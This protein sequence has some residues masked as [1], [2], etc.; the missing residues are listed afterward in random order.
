M[1][2]PFLIVLISNT[3]VHIKSIGFQILES[4][5]DCFNGGTYDFLWEECSCPN[6]YTGKQCETGIH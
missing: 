3:Y 1:P 2:T 5:P 4:S 6:G